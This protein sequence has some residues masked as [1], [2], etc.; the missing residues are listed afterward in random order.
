MPTFKYWHKIDGHSSTHRVNQVTQ[1]GINCCSFSIKLTVNN[2]YQK[3]HMTG[4]KLQFSGTEGG[5]HFANCYTALLQCLLGLSFP[6][7]LCSF[8][9][10]ILD[11][12]TFFCCW[13]SIPR[14]LIFKLLQK[15]TAQPIS[16]PTYDWMFFK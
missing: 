8:R 13:D 2:G 4:F 1:G 11:R 12:E 16:H 14:F 6:S 3:S 7:D 10:L 15:A 9:S 5:H